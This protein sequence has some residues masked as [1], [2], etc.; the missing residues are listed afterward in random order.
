M[1]VIKVTI[2]V[3]IVAFLTAIPALS[4][5]STANE[6]ETGYLW[7]IIS[8]VILIGIT[9]IG[10]TGISFIVIPN[11]IFLDPLRKNLKIVYVWI[12]KK[13]ETSSKWIFE[14]FASQKSK[15][16]AA[17]TRAEYEACKDKENLSFPYVSFEK[18]TLYRLPMIMVDEALRRMQTGNYDGAH[19]YHGIVQY[20]PQGMYDIW[21]AGQ[22]QNDAE[23]INPYVDV[24]MVMKGDK[25][26][27]NL[28]V[29]LAL[30]N[31]E[32]NEDDH[33]HYIKFYHNEFGLY[34][35]FILENNTP[36]IITKILVDRKV[37]DREIQ[38]LI[39]KLS[40]RE[41]ANIQLPDNNNSE[42]KEW[43]DIRR[44]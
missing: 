37:Y 20:F 24:E 5:P 8:D 16:A 23:E 14:F 1:V 29:F 34:E 9:V 22:E 43:L 12:R 27:K 15:D 4:Q 3:W 2:F 35:K 19:I 41:P 18:G 39:V 11:R 42:N 38:R 32:V 26:R 36:V 31:F 33:R 44:Y 6:S 28:R 7:K 10:V 13:K 25:D 40:K 17:T 21:R 30:P